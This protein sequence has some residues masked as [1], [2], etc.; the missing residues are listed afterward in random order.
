MENLPSFDSFDIF[1]SETGGGK[2]IPRAMFMDNK[3]FHHE[4]PVTGNNQDR[5]HYA[6][7]KE[8]VDLGFLVFHSFK[9]STGS[10]FAIYP[11]HEISTAMVEPCNS[12]LITHSNLEHSDYA[13]MVDNEAIYI[14]PQDDSFNTFSSETGGGKPVPRVVF[15]TA[16]MDLKP[17]VINKIVTGMENVTNNY[18][19]GKKV[20]D[21]VPERISD[22]IK[23]PKLEFSI[24]P[25][26]Q[27]ATAVVEPYNSV[28]ITHTS[29]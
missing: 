24:Y 22:Y 5:G 18:A 20:V 21:F 26:P 11:T 19:S 6:I 12:V 25:A 1:F 27:V 13:F 4:Q 9:G 14:G 16:F 8:M 10:G 23:N 17:T 15:N 2:P 3:M 28:L 29:L 7:G